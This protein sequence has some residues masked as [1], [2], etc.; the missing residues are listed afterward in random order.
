[1]PGDPLAGEA[2]D[3]GDV[4][5]AADGAAPGAGSAAR[6]VIGEAAGQGG[7][8]RVGGQDG[9]VGRAEP[10]GGR[11]Q[12]EAARGDDL[13]LTGRGRAHPGLGARREAV[14][15]DGHEVAAGDAAVGRVH[16]PN[17]SGRL[18]LVA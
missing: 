6:V 15:E 5:V 11:A 13:D 17:R 14:A 7:R 1:G 9:D 4:E 8:R 18:E 3:H 16:E 2:V 10:A 12:L